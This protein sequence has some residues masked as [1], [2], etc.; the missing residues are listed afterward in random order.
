MDHG[1][2][3]ERLAEFY[4]LRCNWTGQDGQSCGKSMG[5]DCWITSCGHIFCFEHA[6]AAFDDG[7]SCPV[8]QFVGSRIVQANL[9]RE[10]RA[11]RKSGFLLG[12]A[13]SEILDSAEAALDFWINQKAL[14]A[15]HRSQRCEIL[16]HRETSIAKSVKDQVEASRSEC[17]ELELEQLELQQKLE[18]TE[19]EQ[20]KV[21]SH[22]QRMKRNLA[23][24]EEQYASLRRQVYGSSSPAPA[25]RHQAQP[26]FGFG[27]PMFHGAT[28]A[29]ARRTS[30]AMG[31]S[32]VLGQSFD[33][34]Q[35]RLHGRLQAGRPALV[36][37]FSFSGAQDSGAASVAGNGFGSLR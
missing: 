18:A 6:K 28:P 30:F 3:D 19:A 11:K 20:G 13:P 16:E 14:E 27:S 37:A 25:F 17:Q 15:G 7:E 21:S 8:C 5:E 33:E 2:D 36:P 23:D 35:A 26:A 31:P 29:G 22:I 9:S 12:L 24:A 1:K 10:G 32:K 4:T 34:G